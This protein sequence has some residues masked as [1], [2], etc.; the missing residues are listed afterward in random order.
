MFTGVNKITLY[1]TLT[2]LLFG[3]SL[4]TALFFKENLLWMDEI[5]SYLLISDPSF[6]HLNQAVVSGFEQ[7]PPVFFNL[8]W[9]VAHGIS[10]NVVFLKVVSIILFALTLALFYRYTTQL[11]G[12]PVVNFLLITALAAFTYLN[13]TLAAQIRAYVPFLLVTFLY[14]T[15]VHRLISH[16]ASTRL[17][18][19]HTGVGLLLVLTHNFGLFYLAACGAFFGLLWLWSHERRYWYVLGSFGVIG[20][21]WLLAWYPYFVM[22]AKTGESHSWIPLPTFL[23]FFRIAGEL[24]PTVANKLDGL[25]GAWPVASMLRFLGLVALFAYITVARFKTGVKV[26]LADPA[27]T[28]YLL[29]GFVYAA[30]LFITVV[31]SLMHTSVFLSRYLWP[32]HLLVLYQLV[33]A[34]HFV[35]D[36][37]LAAPS[38]QSAPARLLQRNAGW[39]VP[40]YTLSIAA[41]VFYQSKKLILTPTTIMASVEQLD[42]RYPV[43]LE[44]SLMFMPTWYYNRDRPIRFLLDY[45]SAFDP[46]NDPGATVGY[47]T[48]RNIKQQYNVEAVVPLTEFTATK[49]PHFFVVDE[50]WNYQIERFIQNKS[51]S[52]IRTMPT[53]LNG[54]TIL[55]CV[56][57][58]PALKPGTAIAGH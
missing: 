43:F 31:V 13:I 21:I 7:T 44:S 41:L 11:T 57:N 53:S 36:R 29:A 19:T 4:I 34:F 40:V 25:T 17:L 58:T 37:W 27:F 16:P 46:R 38:N 52:V 8:Y 56:Y 42:R 35:A 47:H 5:L 24:T 51:V 15:V 20:L 54:F 22:Q 2:F 10:E 30:T 55:E 32:S 39:L 26:A 33:Y 3:G 18:I 50:R 48:L 14:F 1:S 9:L 23:S 12:R 45:E 49:V 28:F 6:A